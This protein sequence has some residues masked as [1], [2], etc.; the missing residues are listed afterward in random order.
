MAGQRGI[1]DEGLRGRPAAGSGQATLLAHA[2]EPRT[3]KGLGSVTLKINNQHTPEVQKL[4]S[5]LYVCVECLIGKQRNQ[6]SLGSLSRVPYRTELT[7]SS[8]VRQKG[9][10]PGPPTRNPSP[11][12]HRRPS[13]L[14]TALQEQSIIPGSAPARN[15][16]RYWGSPQACCHGYIPLDY[17][18]LL[19][20]FSL[21]YG[22]SYCMRL[23][24]R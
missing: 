13:G 22:Q 11:R 21:R 12:I 15:V 7:E 1:L 5:L 4:K 19:Y 14:P 3:S 17:I 8:R 16:F 6:F 18:T 9:G 10:V 2:G 23:F 24:S 20:V